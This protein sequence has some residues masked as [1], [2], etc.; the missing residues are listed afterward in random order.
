MTV[1]DL[2]RS[3]ASAS[4][5]GAIE[6]RA[7]RADDKQAL[8]EGCERLSERSR[9]RR[10]LSL[11]GSLTQAE[12]SCFTEVDHHDHEAL[13]AIDRAT[14]HLIG[15][16]RYIRSQV[17]PAV[18]ELAVAVA[19]DWQGQGVGGRLTGALVERARSE[20]IEHFSALMLADNAPMLNLIR[21][22]GAVHDRHIEQGV[23]ELTVD[24]PRG[25][26]GDVSRLLRATARGDVQAVGHTALGLG[27]C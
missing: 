20:G 15:V 7:I 12:L 5:V 14:G 10:F 18:A 24:L 8:R 16:A 11:H 13:V 21:D 4:D 19:D 17:D 6:I 25:G 22:L 3:Q 26:T 9:Y 1:F 2:T 23:V 27:G